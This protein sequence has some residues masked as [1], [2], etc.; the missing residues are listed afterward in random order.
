MLRYS[1][2]YPFTKD[3][4]PVSV[5]NGLMQGAASGGGRNGDGRASGMQA[6]VA[7]NYA[8]GLGLWLE[9]DVENDCVVKQPCV[10]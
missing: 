1:I 9:T 7:D 4:M 3:A 10:F 5:G 6:Q 8:E 2:H